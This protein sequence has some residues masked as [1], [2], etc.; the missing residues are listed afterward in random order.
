MKRRKNKGTLILLLILVVLAVTAFVRQDKVSGNIW[1]LGV[2]L[3]GLSKDQAE[4]ILK[5]KIEEI[6]GGQ[7]TFLAGNRQY[8]VSP[9]ELKIVLDEA[10][11]LSRVDSYIQ[12]KPRLMP[13][14]FLRNGPK[15][16]IPAPVGVESS[17]LN[18]VLSKIAQELSAPAL[19]S[20]YGFEGHDLKILPPQEGQKVLVEDVKK[21]LNSIEGSKVQVAYETIPAPPATNLEPLNLLSEYSTDYDESEKN[22]VQNLILA[23]QAIHGKVI[24]PGE[25]FSFNKEAGERTEEKGYTYAPVIVGDHFELGLAGG[26]CQVTT[27]LFNAAALAGLTFPE[28]HAHG[29]PVEY[30]PPGRDAAVAWDY[31]DL[32]IMNTLDSPC[33]FGVWVE[34]GKV[35]V[36]VFG[37]SDGS[38][39]ELEPVTVKEYPE[40]GKLPGLL[41]ETY[42]VRKQNG[43]EK[44]RKLIMRSYYLSHVQVE[45]SK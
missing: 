7:L 39:Y 35:L 43:E 24:Q 15:T 18:K 17:D 42:L 32:K 22:R 9:E 30:V 25:V 23:A 37:K 1:A 28:V 14:F 20:R 21:A 36:R 16:V 31:L 2:S 38:T 41:V 45:E 34:N 19:G 27:T 26:I 29:I 6:E 13:A 3:G 44:E 8:Q 40:P 11:L 4:K 5:D 12:S 10:G 33:V